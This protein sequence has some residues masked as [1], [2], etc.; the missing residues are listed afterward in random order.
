MA[1]IK[2]GVGVLGF[3]SYLLTVSAGGGQTPIDDS[4]PSSRQPTR[5]SLCYAESWKKGPRQVKERGFR[6]QF[7]KQDQEYKRVLED[8]SGET[9]Y[10]LSVVP[11]VT[12]EGQQVGW[13]VRLRE[14]GSQDSLL[15]P[16]LGIGNWF[17]QEDSIAVLYP[18]DYP[19]VQLGDPLHVPLSAKRVIKVESFY[20]IIQVR[21]YKLAP[22]EPDSP[23]FPLT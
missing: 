22:S 7:A 3:L 23:R 18:A 21:A 10:T 14:E 16:G 8:S 9:R 11:T 12:L 13:N 5:Q 15:Q 19:T 4:M 17:R 2:L 1:P 6:I 20:C